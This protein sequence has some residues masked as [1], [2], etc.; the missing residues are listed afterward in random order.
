MIDVSAIFRSAKDRLA[1]KK[2]LAQEIIIEEETD[3]LTEIFNVIVLSGEPEKTNNKNL[4]TAY[5]NDAINNP[6]EDSYYFV[7]V[8]RMDIDENFL[9]DPFT[10][11]DA[12]KTKKIIN[13]HPI[14]V[15]LST[16]ISKPPQQGDIW[17]A[18]Y[19]SGD[20]K[21]LAL[22]SRVGVSKKF[23]SL[24]N[25]KS[26]FQGGAGNWNKQLPQVISDYGGSQMNAVTP[27]RIR[28]DLSN[29]PD[30]VGGGTFEKQLE[31]FS[32]NNNWRG[33]QP[34]L[35]QFEWL[36]KTKGIKRVIRMNG[37][38]SHDASLPDNRKTLI[39]RPKE[40]AFCEL[41]GIEY[42]FIN[43]HTKPFVPG[44]GYMGAK[45]KV[46]P[47]LEKGDTYIHCRNGA[48]R[49]GYLCAFYRK[50]YEGQTDLESLWQ[51]TIAFN[52]WG[53]ANGRVCKCWAD[54][55]RNTGY[56]KYLDGFYPL[57]Q[58]CQSNTGKTP[59]NRSGCYVCSTYI[60]SRK[61][62]K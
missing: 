57:D 60:K 50:E 49:T 30:Y 47:I 11:K 16:A 13:M 52:T 62:A 18:R 44:Q 40:K 4:G 31:N 17:E 23:L 9:A 53:G 33:C 10:S 21:G 14:G 7:R 39:K 46:M 38:S 26:L 25:K 2:Q 3:K 41:M 45:N 48:D 15:V 5:G 58:W 35:K 56:A 20:R 36:V 51:Y 28:L 19:L 59:S 12:A 27:E 6:Q 61:Y 34:S 43:A 42:T 54:N 24:R 29:E 8:R 37:D 32:S 55:E 1:Y 22:I